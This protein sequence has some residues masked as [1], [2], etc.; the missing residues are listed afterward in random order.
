M[1]QTIFFYLK[2]FIIIIKKTLARTAMATVVVIISTFFLDQESSDVTDV[3][4]AQ[5]PQGNGL[6]D[7]KAYRIGLCVNL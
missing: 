1:I 5:L 2:F 4:S 3:S 6:R 7:D